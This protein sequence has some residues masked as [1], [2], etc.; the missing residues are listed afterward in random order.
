MNS[1]IKITKE[2]QDRIDALAYSFVEG[3]GFVRSLSGAI[4]DLVL[5]YREKERKR[6]TDFRSD[7]DAYERGIRP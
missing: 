1:E 7:P 5:S 4:T 6:K 2:E 3:S